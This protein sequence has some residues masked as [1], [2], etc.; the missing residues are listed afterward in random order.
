MNMKYFAVPVLA[1]LVSPLSAADPVALKTEGDKINYA[2]GVSMINNVKQQGGEVNLDLVIK[3]MMDGLTGEKLLLT[4]DELRRVLAARQSEL[5]EKQKQAANQRDTARSPSVDAG[6]N[7][8]PAAPKKQ[9]RPEQGNDQFQSNATL[10]KQEGQ[11]QKTGQ[12]AQ[13]GRIT[14]NKVGTAKVGT[15]VLERD[16]VRSE[17]RKRA[18]EK[19]REMLQQRRGE[20]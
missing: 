4:E 5:A 12:G 8:E 2:I 7:N 3:G 15:T 18:F 17:T 14:P 11:A 6:R 10:A 19:R 1:L 9:D 20:V 13:S 16:S